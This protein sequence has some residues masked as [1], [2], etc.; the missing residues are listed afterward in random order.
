MTGSALVALVRAHLSRK[1]DGPTVKLIERLKLA[2]RRGHLTKGELHA[3]CLWKSRRAQPLI[4]SNTHDQVREATSLAMVMRGEREKLEALTRLRGVG[5]PMA[6]AILMLLN[7][8]RYA[9]IDIRV[10][11]LL[12]GRG[13]VA[14]NAAGANFT[15][16]QWTTYL[17]V[18]RRLA[19]E[20]GVSAR[21][22]ERTLFKLHQKE[23]EGPLYRPRRN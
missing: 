6:S 2:R 9:V 13:A 20:V 5:I 10:W 15:V 23:H 8:D 16:R 3:V 21:D 19:K 14:G 7:P 12:R 18:V 22:V 17:R 4:L 1:E 11:Q